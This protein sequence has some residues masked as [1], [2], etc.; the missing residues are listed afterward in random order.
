MEK[1][2]NEKHKCNICNR[3]FRDEC[4]LRKH[5]NK[6]RPCLIVNVT[7]EIKQN[8]NRCAFCNRIFSTK[9]NLSVHHKTCKIKNGG[10]DII[11]DKVKIEHDD[12]KKLREENERITKENSELI[13]EMMKFHELMLEKMNEM[14]KNQ[15]STININN[16]NNIT[17]NNNITIN[18]YLTPDLSY[19]INKENLLESPFYKFFIKHLVQTPI[20]LISAIYF[21]PARKENQSIKL[22]NKREQK[23]EVM[24]EG[25]KTILIFSPMDLYKFRDHLYDTALSLV[26][27]VNPVLSDIQ[28]GVGKQINDNKDKSTQIELDAQKILTKLEDGKNLA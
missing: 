14:I 25:R 19:M 13:K 18:N 2:N 24:D 17:N 26:K 8:P 6:K 21:D 4:N 12:N 16:T 9:Y 5:K 10:L 15:S 11:Y 20:E 27:E 3:T 23:M 1:Q 22:I 28:K 7:E